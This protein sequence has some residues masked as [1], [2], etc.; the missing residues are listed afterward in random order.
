MK[1]P[2]QGKVPSRGGVQERTGKESGHGD[3][4]A[5]ERSK[6][7]RGPCKGGVQA[8]I[9]KGSIQ[10]RVPDRERVQA[11]EESKQGQ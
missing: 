7:R 3:V 5:G 10:G 8:G 2:R 9:V 4:H 6:Q 1:G 11:G